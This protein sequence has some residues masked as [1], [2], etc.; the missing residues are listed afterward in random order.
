MKYEKS[1]LNL[2]VALY[3]L[4]LAKPILAE[5][6][7]GGVAVGGGGASVGGVAAGNGVFVEGVSVGGFAPSATPAPKKT[8]LIDQRIDIPG[9]GI[10]VEEGESFSFEIFDEWRFVET[11]RVKSNVGFELWVNGNRKR[12]EKIQDYYVIYVNEAMNEVEFKAP[13]K[14]KLEIGEVKVKCSPTEVEVYKP[15]RAVQLDLP[16]RQRGVWLATEARRCVQKLQPHV[17]PRTEYV[18][19]LLPI[20]EAAIHA[21]RVAYKEEDLSEETRKALISLAQQIFSAKTL[22]TS[23]E[24]RDDEAEANLAAEL[25]EIA[26]EIER[27]LKW[28]H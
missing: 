3:V 10:D 9:N 17:N 2:F 12:I 19:F 6:A 8:D 5:V 1:I 15:K 18:R 22:L 23:L 11:M 28:T 27:R 14:T 13:P 21:Y 7:V 16:A 4:A 24:G 20:R 25:G 26:L